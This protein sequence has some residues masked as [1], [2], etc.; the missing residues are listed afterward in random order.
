MTPRDLLD[1]SFGIFSVLLTF[2]LS[3]AI[4]LWVASEW[5]NRK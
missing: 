3:F 4:F 1:W 2:A 5:R